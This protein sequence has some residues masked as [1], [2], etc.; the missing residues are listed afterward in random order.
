MCYE[1]LQKAPELQTNSLF[2]TNLYTNRCKAF[3]LVPAG[4]PSGERLLAAYWL[5]TPHTSSAAALAVHTEAA[6]CW[7]DFSFDEYLEQKS[8]FCAN[9]CIFFK[10]STIVNLLL[11]CWLAKFL[12]WAFYASE[13]NIMFCYESFY[14][15]LTSNDPIFSMINVSEY[16]IKHIFR[17]S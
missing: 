2:F 7:S 5:C 13:F 3:C 10:L 1:G 4:I 17:H 14:F 16:V 6:S 9:F 11:S 8:I 15:V 12:N